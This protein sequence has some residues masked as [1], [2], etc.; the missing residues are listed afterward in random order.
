[1]PPWRQWIV[2]N[3]RRWRLD[4]DGAILRLA[5]D[6][7]EAIFAEAE[8]IADDDARKRQRYFALQ[9]QSAARI[10]AMVELAESEEEVVILPDRLDADPWLL[11]V[12]N[13]VIDLKTGD[14]RDGRREDYITLIA[15]VT[16]DLEATCPNWLE[17][18]D[19]ITNKN[20]E[21]IAYLQ[22][23]MGYMLTGSVREEVLFFAHGGGNNGKTTYRE[24]LYELLGD[25]AITADAGLLL[26]RR[27]A[28]SAT[29]EVARLK[30]RRLVCI[31]E[32][33]EN[34]RLNE[35][36]VKFITSTDTITARKLYHDFFDFKPTHKTMLT[37]NHRPIV[38]GTD[39]GIWRRIHLVPF[40]VT[41]PDYEI[42][43]NYREEELRPEH[44]GILNWALDGLK[45]Y[46]EIGLAPPDAVRGATTEY[47]EDMDVLAQW[48]KDRCEIGPKA[49]VPS[50]DAYAD[51]ARWADDN[52]GW[53]MSHTRF[54]RRLGDI[55]DS[56][57]TKARGDGSS[58][59][60]S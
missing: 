25:Y 33:S 49:R 12:R 23:K 2:W 32:T 58:S 8:A 53:T 17:C 24:T 55:R 14:F 11:G 7:V 19:K 27:Q 36:R 4:E 45:A 22:R 52:I 10:A 35:A 15:G 47:R 28:G 51:Y 5:K 56:A 6:T 30:G 13:G 48:L 54:I 34:D 31:N 60:C 50:T 3:G 18:L 40:T 37:S 57:R 42:K 20:D 44:P 38:R 59:D 21:L 39:E 29:P 26:E 16:Y 43:K 9:S 46:R 41:I 1:M